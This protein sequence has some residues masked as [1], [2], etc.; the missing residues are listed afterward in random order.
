MDYER[1]FQLAE[2]YLKK[3]DHGILHTQRVFDIAQKNFEIPSEKKEL[4]YCAIILHD[5]G[6]CSIQKQYEEGPKIAALLLRQMDRDENFIQ[7]VCEIICT[8]HDHPEYPSLAFQIL[9]D[10]DKFVMFSTEEFY[11]YNS[12]PNFDWKKTIKS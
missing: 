8:H 3:N 6:G 12:N 1:L 10:S 4:V 2:P 9:N 11:Y 5:I 7:K